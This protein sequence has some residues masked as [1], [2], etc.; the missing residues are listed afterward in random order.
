MPRLSLLLA[1]TDPKQHN[2]IQSAWEGIGCSRQNMLQVDSGQRALEICSA[3]D[4]ELLILGQ[5][6]TDISPQE[7]LSRLKELGAELPVCMLLAPRHGGQRQMF[8]QASGQG[9][10]DLLFTPFDSEELALRLELGLR[11]AGQRKAQ[12]RFQDLAT[13]AG[14]GYWEYAPNQEDF[15]ASRA[16]QSLLGY[17][18]QQAPQGCELLRAH[19][20]E[21]DVQRLKQK[22]QYLEPGQCFELELA[23][24]RLDR[25]ERYIRIQGK[26]EAET[27]NSL[28]VGLFQ[29]ITQQ[30]RV[31]NKLIE[32][33]EHSS[34][35][36]AAL[37]QSGEGIVLTDQ[38]F[39]VVYVN[40][41][42][43]R[44]CGFKA[45]ELI[46]KL[47]GRQEGDL[48]ADQSWRGQLHLEDKN[49]Q[50]RQVEATVSE[51][52]SWSG[53][54]V[55]YVLLVRDITE[56]LQLQQ[57]LQQAQKMEAIGTLAGGIAHDFNNM[58]MGMQGFTEL[59]LS[60]LPEDCKAAKHLQ[61]VLQTSS[62]AKDLVQQILTFSRQSDSEKKPLQAKAVLKEVLKLLQA[63][64]P[65]NIELQTRIDPDTP[66]ILADPSQMQ[67]VI[68]NLCTNAVQA[69]PEGGTLWVVLQG[70]SLGW[71]DKDRP[72][73][74]GPGKYL[75]LQ[76]QDTGQGM[77]QDLAQRI[78]D[79][80]F[81]TKPRGQ[82]TGLGLSVV[83]GI[84]QEIS[85]Y[86]EVGSSQ[87]EGT[88]FSVFIPALQ[89]P[90]ADL[91]KEEQSPCM[92]QGRGNILFVDDQQDIVRWGVRALEGLG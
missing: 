51:V 38:D 3:E 36:A 49:G 75:L 19:F 62:R 47:P 15:H 23:C 78:F 59:A 56:K 13:K 87:G 16:L 41:F 79:P 63:T 45:S 29:D 46:S 22:M 26:K 44:V 88:L 76:V 17:T 2:R 33:L 6:L 42:F 68:M 32:L 58:L 80:F 60:N 40:P 86:I 90:G 14:L 70:K 39:R 27:E 34:M 64:L 1:G 48:Q 43:D 4:P 12:L 24:R 54:V 61:N 30:K 21:Q 84:L 18:K 91:D 74:L 67:Q 10:E 57:Q 55:N 35:Q 81:T 28:V 92:V 7:L 73:D 77:D 20:S 25:E 85:G 83:Y 31:Q 71:E 53:E 72:E 66:Q 37:E 8:L 9:L 5:G 52:R 69:M 65:A 11:K 89:E 82:G 50:K